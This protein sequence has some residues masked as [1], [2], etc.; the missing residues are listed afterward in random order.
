MFSWD[1]LT[2][3]HAVEPGRWS[4]ELT[5]RTDARDRFTQVIVDK[6]LAICSDLRDFVYRVGF[7]YQPIPKPK[8]SRAEPS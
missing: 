4:N 3:L 5:G 1:A 6:G 8:D 2:S 7:R